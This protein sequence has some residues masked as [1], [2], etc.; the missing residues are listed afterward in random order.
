MSA[1]PDASHPESRPDHP[2]PAHLAA[3]PL[4][5]QVPRTAVAQ[6]ADVCPCTARNHRRPGRRPRGRVPTSLPLR[7]GRQPVP[8]RPPPTAAEQR[9]VASSGAHGG[10]G[11]V[12]VAGRGASGPPAG[13]WLGRGELREAAPARG[14]DPGGQ[15][16]T[17][18]QCPRAG[19][20]PDLGCAGWPGMLRGRRRG[21]RARTRPRRRPEDRAAA[22]T[23]EGV[24]TGDRLAASAPYASARGPLAALLPP[25]S[26]SPPFAC[27][28]GRG[29]R[30]GGP[31][32][33]LDVGLGLA[34]LLGRG[35]AQ[36]GGPG[37]SVEARGVQHRGQ[38][39]RRAS[40]GDSRQRDRGRARRISTSRLNRKPTDS[41]RICPIIV[42]NIA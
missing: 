20:P 25:R 21:G 8:S 42:W 41:S 38:R 26:G 29:A 22:R 27:P 39:G 6:V 36:R 30:R 15:A 18:H 2:E 5:P 17:Q 33:A 16:G 24:R 40:V 37:R 19:R 12:R 1:S 13:P 28:S 23:V 3:R 14:T 34:V 10:P 9:Q 32:G 35:V 11:R 4:G 31:G 7:P